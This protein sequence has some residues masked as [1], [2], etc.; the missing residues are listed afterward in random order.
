M[1][2]RY[3]FTRLALAA[4]LGLMAAPEEVF[5]QGRGSVR[6]AQVSGARGGQAAAG[7]V[8]FSGKAPGAV[9]TASA[10]G[11]VATT[12]G[13][14]TVAAGKVSRA[15]AVAG[16]G[17]AAAGAGSAKGVVV[18]TPSGQVVRTGSVKHAGVVAHPAGGTA[19][20]Y[21]SVRYAGHGPA[22]TTVKGGAVVGATTVTGAAAVTATKTT[23]SGAVAVQPSINTAYLATL[24]VGYQT[25]TCAGTTY[26]RHGGVYYLPQF[27]Q[28]AVV[29]VV[30]PTPSGTIVVV[31]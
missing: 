17:G 4:G 5:A 10:K 31:P 3:G 2:M 15:G 12:P 30:V 18:K 19:A 6:H 29:Y 7:S 13:G 14:A 28:G 16:P 24:P 8:R 11:A 25:C 1:N 9:G 20:A 26:Y 23:V 27:Y 22:V 21:G